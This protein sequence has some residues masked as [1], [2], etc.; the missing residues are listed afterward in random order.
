MR[1]LKKY[2]WGFKGKFRKYLAKEPSFPII[3]LKSG[4]GNIF[5]QL[6]FLRDLLFF[7]LL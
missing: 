4:W 5:F 2:I 3:L 6:Y 1:V 7:V